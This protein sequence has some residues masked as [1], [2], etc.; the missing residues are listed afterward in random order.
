MTSKDNNIHSKPTKK[1]GFVLKS[2]GFNGHI[3]IHLEDDF[4]PKDFLF[5]EI[6]QKFV[7]FAIQSF[8]KEALIVK[9]KEFDTIDQISD[10]I[11]L[12]I[13]EII[14]AQPDEIE[15]IIGYTLIDNETG[16]EYTIT[17]I[18]EYPGNVLLEFRNGFKDSL[19]PL[20]DDFITQ[21]NHSERKIFASFPDGILDL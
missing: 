18:I 15:T 3:R 2:H 10:L 7:P 12:P 21:I 6:N 5:M 19:I 13:I 4:I 1:V 20:H 17:D 9:L 11:S 14:D 8:N 16:I